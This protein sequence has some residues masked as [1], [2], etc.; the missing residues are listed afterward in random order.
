[1]DELAALTKLERVYRES[2][3]LCFTETWLKQDIPDSVISLTGFTLVRADRSEVESGSSDHNLVNLLPVYTP[4]VKQQSPQG[5][6]VMIW[7]E[8]ASEQLRDCFNITDWDVLCSPHGED[9]DSLI[10]CVT[11][12]IHFCV[13]NTVPSRTVWCFPNNKP[14]VTSELKALLNEKKRAFLSEDK[15]EL[16]RVQRE[17]KYNI[18]RC[19]AS[20]KKKLEQGMEQNNIREVWR[21][22]KHI[23]GHGKSGDVLQVIGDQA[24][25]NE[26][27]LFFNRFDLARHRAPS[28]LPSRQAIHPQLSSFTPQLPAQ[29][30]ALLPTVTVDQSTVDQST[31]TPFRL[32]LDQV[33]RELKKTKA[34]KAT[35]P[36]NISSRLLREC[37]D[38]LC[39]VVLFMFNLSLSLE[40]VPALWKTSCVVPVPKISHPKE[41]NHY[42]PI[43][44]TSHLMKAMERIVLSYLRT[45]LVHL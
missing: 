9:V 19:K 25:A 11:D 38:Q 44:L 31:S 23:S 15:E 8:E 5:K 12:Y 20:Y 26:L 40:R 1:M 45:Q 33:R 24:W 41:L 10:H 43:V 42:R 18:R 7:T 21:G 39:E 13:E 16:R 34:R 22:L 29:H 4:V 3:L 6:E 27:N 37:A 35:G 2:S 28:S 30:S 14:W 36:D 17:L 32:T